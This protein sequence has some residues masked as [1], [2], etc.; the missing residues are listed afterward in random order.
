MSETLP[1]TLFYPLH[2]P[3]KDRA[4]CRVCQ[5]YFEQRHTVFIYTRTDVHANA[6][7]S[8]LWTFRQESFIPHTVIDEFTYTID[9]P[10]VIG[11]HDS[12][13]FESQI[14]IN[15]SDVSANHINFYKSFKT[16]VDFA[17]KSDDVEH[18]KSR[19]RYKLFKDLGFAMQ[20][21]ESLPA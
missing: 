14:L 13:R 15:A 18:H 20:L 8:L 21:A 3:D 6:L 7:D 10:V 16:I 5:H 4:I 2:S 17:D 12:N 9:C 11:T 19:E 1:E